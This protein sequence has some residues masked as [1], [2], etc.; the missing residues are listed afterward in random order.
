MITNSRP[1]CRRCLTGAITLMG[2]TLA[3][4]AL[5]S[6]SSSSSSEGSTDVPP[7]A[8]IAPST[9]TSA[10]N[11]QTLLRESIRTMLT[12]LAPAQ[13]SLLCDGMKSDPNGTAESF[14]R[15]LSA[16]GVDPVEAGAALV[17]ELNEVCHLS[18]KPIAPTSS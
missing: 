2:C 5:T 14:A 9:Q 11:S 12:D 3:L 18:L 13:I 6:C 7:A 16:T 4:L 1:E 10:P 15:P 17:E 8:S